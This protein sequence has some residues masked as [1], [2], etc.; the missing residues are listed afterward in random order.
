MMPAMAA[1]QGKD[2]V[3]RVSVQKTRRPAAASYLCKTPGEN[4]RE[5]TH[6]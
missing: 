2:H 5:V 3:T 6:E 4:N 1:S